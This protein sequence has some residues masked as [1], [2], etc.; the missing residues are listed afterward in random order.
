MSRK[1]KLRHGRGEDNA[2]P[3]N[4]PAQAAARHDAR[5]RRFTPIK[6]GIGL[7][8]VTLTIAA[9]L[10][11]VFRGSDSAAMPGAA[12]GP[13]QLVNDAVAPAPLPAAASLPPPAPGTRVPLNDVD[14]V[15]GKP[16]T[17][18]S[19][20]VMYKGY[21]IGFCCTESGGYQGGWARLSEKEKDAFV[22]KY[23][24]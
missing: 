4:H 19:P 10:G 3:R 24:K 18:S 20:T 12:A 14:P 13:T 15:G 2:P 7:G 1:N 22:R 16:I 11:S 17:P 21:T 8:V 5:P 6:V 9:L 23:L